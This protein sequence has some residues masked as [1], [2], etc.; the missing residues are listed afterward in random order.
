[1]CKTLW[2]IPFSY[3]T[4]M[5]SVPHWECLVFPSGFHPFSVEHYVFSILQLAVLFVQITSAATH[6]LPT[7]TH[8]RILFW[9]YYVCPSFSKMAY[10]CTAISH[11]NISPQCLGY[12]KQCMCWSLECFYQHAHVSCVCVTRCRGRP[13]L[14]TLICQLCGLHICLCV[15][16]CACMRMCVHKGV[17][18]FV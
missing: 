16:T 3:V 7:E 14:A 11:C 9:D 15:C 13:T 18:M 10:L 4:A 5:C 12:F 1:M 17:K 8:W 6:I 2:I